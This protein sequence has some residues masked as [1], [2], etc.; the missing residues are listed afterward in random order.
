MSAKVEAVADSTAVRVALW[1]ALHLEI[2]APPHVFEDRI[3]LEIAAPD[4][5]WRDRPDMHPEW[6]SAFRAS[7][8][9]RARF[10]EDLVAERAA[11]GVDQYVRTATSSFAPAQTAIWFSPSRATVMRAVPVAEASV[12]L[13]PV[14]STPA[15]ASVRTRSEPASS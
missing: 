7:I 1:R 10:L 5:G 2:D 4:P 14:V 6:T 9:A 8:V 11:N 15:S 13:M 12:V 3:G